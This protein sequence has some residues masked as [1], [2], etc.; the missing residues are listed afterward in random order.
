MSKK[1]K[2][3]F[4]AFKQKVESHNPNILVDE[5]TR[6]NDL[7][8]MWV[9]FKLGVE[10]KSIKDICAMLSVAYNL[11]MVIF[12]IERSIHLYYIRNQNAFFRFEEKPE[13]ETIE[14]FGAFM[15]QHRITNELGVLEIIRLQQKKGRKNENTGVSDVKGV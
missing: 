9:V 15:E 11:D 13:S 1:Q 10:L 2:Q 7:S 5:L 12:R 8:T 14:E 4:L 3:E 6:R